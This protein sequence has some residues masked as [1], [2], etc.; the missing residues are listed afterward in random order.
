MG[1]YEIQLGAADV[2]VQRIVSPSGI[3]QPST[4]YPVTVR[5][6]NGSLN[7]LLNVRLSYQLGNATPVVQNFTLSLQPNHY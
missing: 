1:A 4:T 3:V 6:I 7:P 5:L 2:F